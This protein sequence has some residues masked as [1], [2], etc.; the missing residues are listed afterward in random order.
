MS[1][2]NADQTDANALLFT[3][4]FFLQIWSMSASELNTARPEWMFGQVEMDSTSDF[5]L[6]MEGKASNGGFAIDQLIFTPGGC[7]SK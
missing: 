4:L 6:L 7:S 3:S 5:R 2:I 1:K